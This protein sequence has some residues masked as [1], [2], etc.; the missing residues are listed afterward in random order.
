[1]V[2]LRV[3]WMVNKSPT[4]QDQYPETP[5]LLFWGQR[6]TPSLPAPPLPILFSRDTRDHQGAAAAAASGVAKTVSEAAGVAVVVGASA[7]AVVAVD[8]ATKGLLVKS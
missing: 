7:E 2:T 6:R 5:R 8:S 4:R 3:P 1:M